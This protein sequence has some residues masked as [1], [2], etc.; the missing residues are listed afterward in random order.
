MIKETVPKINDF[1]LKRVGFPPDI[2]VQVVGT[3][4]E[5]RQD[6]LKKASNYCG[7]DDTPPCYLERE[8]TNQYDP[9]AVAVFL[10]YSYDKEKGWEFHK[11]GYLPRDYMI[12][13]RNLNNKLDKARDLVYI[14]LDNNL[15]QVQVG[16][17]G[18]Y[19]QG[20]TFGCRLGLRHWWKFEKKLFRCNKT[21]FNL[22]EG[23]YYLYLGETP[24]G[25]DR[26]YGKISSSIHSSKPSASSFGI[27]HI[28]PGSDS[29]KTLEE[30]KEAH[31]VDLLVSLDKDLEK[32]YQEVSGES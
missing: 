26:Y 7:P 18:V 31:L 22:T 27:I 24:A 19:K 11:V 4:H 12:A 32:K 25:N 17:D 3:S 15:G 10:G 2:L 13:S 8:P 23:E 29:H 16:V 14:L 30:I 28:E 6:Y 20:G 1:M 5:D 9:N 21:L